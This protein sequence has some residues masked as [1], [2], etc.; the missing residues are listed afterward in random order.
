MLDAI[1]D[2]SWDGEAASVRGEVPP[3]LVDCM[4]G[5]AAE[6]GRGLGRSA[7]AGGAS[8]PFRA[9]WLYADAGLLL[10][11]VRARWC[12]ESRRLYLD[13]SDAAT[14]RQRLAVAEA[15]SCVPLPKQELGIGGVLHPPWFGPRLAAALANREILYCPEAEALVA[16]GRTG[17]PA[18]IEADAIVLHDVG[19]PDA[20]TLKLEPTTRCNFGCGFCYGRHL[21][22]GDL[23]PERFRAILAAIPGLKAVEL[24]GEG[25]PLLNRRIYDYVA[26]CTAAGL[27]THLTSNGSTLSAR[28]VDRLVDA[29]LKSLAISLES[30]DPERFARFRPGGDLARVLEGVRRAVDARDERKA[31]I[32]ISIWTTVLRETLSE[33]ERFHDYAAE[34]GADLQFFQLLNPMP[35]YARFYDD[36][37][38]ANMIGAEEIRRLAEDPAIPAPT[39]AALADALWPYRQTSCSIFMHT[40]MINWR[41]ELTPCCLLKAPD[42]PPFGDIVRDG[43]AQVWAE[44]RFTRFR[45]ALAHGVIPESCEGCPDVAAA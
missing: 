15:A 24:T 17:S 25:E 30:L 22:Q 21:E 33:I 37:L 31:P 43:L 13:P 3:A 27:H 41:G 40:L 34:I 19:L 16:D 44:P 11:G 29:G 28:N 14:L 9:A 18:G 39:R 10:L 35:S 23:A 8:L 20:I 5:A 7:I 36:S 38:R 1:V 2:L 6:G 12:V 42:F 45:F 32:T 4:T 26:E